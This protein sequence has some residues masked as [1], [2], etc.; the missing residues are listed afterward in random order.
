[1]SLNVYVQIY[2]LFL[3]MQFFKN[4]LKCSSL[5]ILLFYYFFSHGL[6]NH[7]NFQNIHSRRNI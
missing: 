5:E 2:R 4:N 6:I 3:N 1:M 7:F